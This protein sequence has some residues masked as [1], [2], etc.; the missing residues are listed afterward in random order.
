MSRAACSLWPALGMLVAALGCGGDGLARVAVEG[1]VSQGGQ[2]LSAGVISFLPA[3]GNNGP[4]ANTDIV[5]GR[6][7]FDRTNGPIAGAHR[8]LVRPASGGKAAAMEK[9]KQTS[10]PAR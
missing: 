4:A 7:R 1:S 10:K 8:V 5:E 9:S 2:P 6:Y 3:A